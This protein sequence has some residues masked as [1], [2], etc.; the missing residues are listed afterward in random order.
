MHLHLCVPCHAPTTKTNI[1]EWKVNLRFVLLTINPELS[2]GIQTVFY[3]EKN[4]KRLSCL[5]RTKQPDNFQSTVIESSED[6]WSFPVF[7]C[8]R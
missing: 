5:P 1:L 7:A 8:L 2:L 3:R 6:V 4:N